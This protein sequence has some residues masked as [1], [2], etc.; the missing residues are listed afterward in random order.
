MIIIYS[1]SPSK[2]LNFILKFVFNVLSGL[3]IKVVHDVNEY[4]NYSGAKIFYS[5]N[6]PGTGIWI[7][8]ENLLFENNIQSFPLNVIDTNWG[9]VFFA[10]PENKE[11]PYDIF[12]AIFYLLS[13]YEEYLPFKPDTFGRF[14]YTE[15]IL[16]KEDVLSKPVINIWTRKLQEILKVKFPELEYKYPAYRFISTIDIDNAFAYRE[17][18]FVRNA[19]GYIRSLLQGKFN[20]IRERT[21]VL[22]GNVNDPYDT[23]DYIKTTHNKYSVVPKVFVLNGKYSK[24]DKNISI[25]NAA[26]KKILKDL[27]AT[28]VTGIH[29]SYRSN[30]NNDLSKEKVNLEKVLEKKIFISRQHFLMLRFPQT[31]NQ[32]LSNGIHEDYSMGYSAIAGYRAGTCSSFP[33]FDLKNNCETALMIYPFVWMDRTLR[34][35][36]KM[37]TD[38]AMKFISENISQIKELGGTFVSLWHN[39]SLSDKGYWKEWRKVFEYMMN[40][41]K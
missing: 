5:K 32:L 9:K 39:E 2:R 26:F 33:F 15:S 1:E 37:N 28:C 19:G 30:F 38:E 40:V 29:P 24:Y 13:R 31:Y 41:T 3:E 23:Y 8:S 36:M 4:E 16:Y 35:H 27:S 25:N 7:K 11:I 34:Q 14:P 21:K 22:K 12:S 10:T 6:K 20:E 18:G 17:K